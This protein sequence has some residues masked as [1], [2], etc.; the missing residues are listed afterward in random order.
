MGK[1]QLRYLLS[2]YGTVQSH[3]KGLAGLVPMT[4]SQGMGTDRVSCLSLEKRTLAQEARVRNY[5]RGAHIQKSG[6]RYKGVIMCGA[7]TSKCI[8]CA[9][10]YLGSTHFV[11]ASYVPSEVFQPTAS[12]AYLICLPGLDLLFWECVGFSTP[13]LFLL[14]SNLRPEL[15]AYPTLPL[16]QHFESH[17]VSFLQQLKITLFIIIMT[18][19]PLNKAWGVYS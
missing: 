15:P 13:T 8:L 16:F 5:K 4:K 9:T 3:R 12:L 2:S 14:Q 17:R 7:D 18:S 10:Y 11:V 6:W 19:R 1:R